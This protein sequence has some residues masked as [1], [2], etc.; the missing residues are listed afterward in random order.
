M[1]CI[2]AIDREPEECE[3]KIKEEVKASETRV[4]VEVITFKGASKHIR[5]S[6][7]VFA[8]DTIFDVGA[9]VPPIV[10]LP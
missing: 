5:S 2:K 10:K 1:D 3:E 8:I 7:F 9:H 6:T 4:M